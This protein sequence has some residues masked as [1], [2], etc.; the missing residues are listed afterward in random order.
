VKRS[1]FIL[2][3]A[4]SLRADS[5]NDVLLRMDQAAQKFR[6]LSA[7]VRKTDYSDVLSDSTVEEGSFK[8][9]KAGKDKVVLLA[10]FTGQDAH[11]VQ[12]AG[13]QVK[14]YH[15]KAKS[16][17]IYDMRKFTKAANEYLFVG[18][19][20]T[21]AELQK[22]YTVTLGGA[23]TVDGVKTT[24]LDLAPKSAEAKKLFNL[25]QLWIPEGQ[26]NPMQEKILS[27]KEG[28]DYKLFQFSN[29]KIRTV[30]EPALPASEFELKLPAD[31][32]EIIAGK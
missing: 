29:A 10:D 18:F 12:I 6:S 1:T 28:K 15:P 19:G 25:I 17:E 3:L 5:L 27:G 2:A 8:M 22:T 20:N 21:S 14:I 31:V 16:V 11:T 30:S 7:K 24:R 23:E 32:K 26:S 13:N 4:A 9:M